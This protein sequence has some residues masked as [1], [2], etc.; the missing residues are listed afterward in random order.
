MNSKLNRL[1]FISGIFYGGGLMLAMSY[2]LNLGMY[3]YTVGL[4]GITVGGILMH[5]AKK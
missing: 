1:W 4:A 3:S 2:P 5:Y